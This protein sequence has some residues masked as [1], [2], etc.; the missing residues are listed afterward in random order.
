MSLFNSLFPSLI[1]HRLLREST[2]PLVFY[3]T[4]PTRILMGAK[5]VRLKQKSYCLWL[6]CTTWNAVTGLWITLGAGRRGMRGQAFLDSSGSLFL[7]QDL[8]EN[9][10]FTPGLFPRQTFRFLLGSK[11]TLFISICPIPLLALHSLFML[12]LFRLHLFRTTDTVRR[13]S[14]AQHPGGANCYMKHCGVWLVIG[15]AQGMLG[16]CLE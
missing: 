6:P 14:R 1:S 3:L 4:R 12:L 15:V 7:L 10:R 2:Q 11:E 8:H 13:A 5:V 16:V 9:S